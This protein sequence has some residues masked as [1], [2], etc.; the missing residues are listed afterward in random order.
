MKLTDLLSGTKILEVA[1]SKY[2]REI[3]VIKNF[4]WGTHI[5]VNDYTQSGGIVTKIWKE[6][7][8]K[9]LVQKPH[10]KN[11]LILGLGGGSA[12][13]LVAQYWVGSKITGV[14]IDSKIVNLGKKYLNLN[15]SLVNIKIADAYN[16]KNGKYDLI[17]IDLYSGNKFPK[18]FLDEKFLNKV[19]KMLNKDGIAIFNHVKNSRN[20]EEVKQLKENLEKIFKKV[21]DISPQANVELI[22]YN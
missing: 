15:D 8:K 6:T 17:L 5:K 4:T 7:L 12:A 21:D 10:I 22:C 20:K 16:F 19:K 9:I 1:H 14:D 3:T 13:I 2:N 18:K 11:C